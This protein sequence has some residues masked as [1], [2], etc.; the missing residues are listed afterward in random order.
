MRFCWFWVRVSLCSPFW[1]GICNLPASVQW[2]T[3][4]RL[5]AEK[6]CSFGKWTIWITYKVLLLKSAIAFKIEILSVLFQGFV[7]PFNMKLRKWLF[8]TFIWST[9]NNV[10]IWSQCIPKFLCLGSGVM[11]SSRAL[12][13]SAPDLGLTPSTAK[14]FT[15]SLMPLF[16]HNYELSVHHTHFQIYMFLSHKFLDLFFRSLPFF[17]WTRPFS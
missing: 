14:K 17:F 2:K 11:L 12:I 15:T 16:G 3:P 4:L 8:L 6:Q 10:V 7:F 5:Q 9:E 13:Q 1:P